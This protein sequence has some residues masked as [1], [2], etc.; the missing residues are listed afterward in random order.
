[1]EYGVEEVERAREIFELGIQVTDMNMPESIWKA[2]IDMEIQLKDYEKVR[3]L[4]N[5]L[6]QKTKHIKVWISYAQFEA[7]IN[8]VQ[9][10]RDI[11]LQADRFFKD[12]GD[13][14]EERVMLLESWRDME[15]KFKDPEHIDSVGKR[16]PKRVKK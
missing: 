15:V 6:L 5:R 9:K 4:Y 12:N 8:E 11:Y 13:L 2:Y 10:S 3:G 1:M 7:D 16:M 14:K